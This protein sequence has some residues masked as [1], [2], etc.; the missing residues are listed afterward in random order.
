MSSQ[1]ESEIGFTRKEYQ[2]YPGY[3]VDGFTQSLDYSSVHPFHHESSGASHSLNYQETPEVDLYRYQQNN[4]TL[5]HHLSSD[6]S[7]QGTNFS[8]RTSCQQYTLESSSGTGGHSVYN[9]PSSQSFSPNGSPVSHQE[10]QSCT[11]VL[12]QEFQSY[13]PVQHHSP[14]NTY[15]SPLSVSCITDNEND[16]DLL[17][18][19]KELESAILVPDSDNM[20]SFDSIFQAGATRGSG[21][22]DKWRQMTESICRGD[23]KQVLVYCA[24]SISDGDLTMAHTL[25][26]ELRKMVSVTGEP[27]QRVGAYLLEGLVARLA[28]SGSSI[29]KSLKCSEP[30]SSELLSYM[31]LL[32]EICPF[33]KFGYMSANGAI[34]EAVKDERRI[35]IIDFQIA[36]G[37]Q[38]LSLIQALGA[39][40]GGAPY[41]RITGIDDSQSA[42]ARGGGLNIVGQRLSKHAESCNVPFEFNAA[43]MSGCAVELGNLA[44]RR[45]EAIAVNF[46]YMLH[47]MPDESVSTENHRDRLLRL[48]KSLAPKV[49]TLVEQECNTNTAPF[50]QRF[51]ETLS[52]YT[53]MFESIDVTL[54]R[55]RKERINVEQQCLARDIVNII[56]CEGPERVERHEL[57]GKWRVRFKMAGFTPYPLSSVVNSTIKDLLKKYCEYYRLE[58]R[59]GALYLGWKNKALVSSSA[60]I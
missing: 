6:D 9:S 44:I 42:Y 35:H 17:L 30:T 38:W 34:A 31:S 43:A 32:Y 46:P 37:S 2:Y 22:Q 27:I 15:G 26:A 60:W 50:F 3:T 40:P 49:V 54:P 25:I 33:F 55:E 4:Q 57:L 21:E 16:N 12:G 5:D 18:K 28:S 23:L 8:V 53:S 56:A 41:I 39:R 11:P 51:I 14:H 48:V 47:H 52:Y 13:P 1:I 36:Q 59:N 29:Y 45:G 24:E 7:S 10:Y 20:G 19:I 58:E